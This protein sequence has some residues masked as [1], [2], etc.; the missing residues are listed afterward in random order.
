MHETTFH[1]REVSYF[2]QQKKF[3]EIGMLSPRSAQEVWNLHR[4]RRDCL[5]RRNRNGTILK[6]TLTP[7][8]GIIKAGRQ[9][10]HMETAYSL[11]QRGQEL[12]ETMNPAQA[13]V[14]L[15]RAKK[16]EPKKGSIREALARAYFNYGQYHVARR[17]FERALS[18]DPTNHY[19]HFGL[20]L[21][22][23][24]LGNITSAVRHL[25]LA[26][27]MEPDEAYKEVLSSLVD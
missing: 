3:L 27:A 25:K 22:H 23:K 7:L 1:I 24:R 6:G 9:V 8:S 11:L 10:Y 19:A 4:D 5:L 2:V 12:L 21:C 16:L 20:G 18:I 14:V 17:E 26:V 15:E 13:A